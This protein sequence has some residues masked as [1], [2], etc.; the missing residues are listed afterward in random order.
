[1]DELA[2]PEGLSAKGRT[3]A[4]VILRLIKKDKRTETGGCRAFFTPE[5]WW[6]RG[7]HY[8]KGCVL[9]V[10]HDG[11]SLAS[12]FN[13]DY[14]DYKAIDRMDAALSKHGYRAENCTSTY[15]AVYAE[16]K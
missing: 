2:I 14:R 7:N 3:A 15:T 5:E 1:M 11:G 4:T 9:I 10:C 6:D 13:Y 16:A 8:G 12:Y